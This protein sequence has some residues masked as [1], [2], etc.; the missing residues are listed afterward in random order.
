MFTVLRGLRSKPTK[1]REAP[2]RKSSTERKL[3]K[4]K[5]KSGEVMAPHQQAKSK[6]KQKKRHFS[7][8]I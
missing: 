8:E 5:S 3:L 2:L 4:L 6:K 1:F 7:A